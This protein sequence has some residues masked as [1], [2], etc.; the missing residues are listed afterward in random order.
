MKMNLSSDV[1]RTAHPARRRAGDEK[2]ARCGDRPSNVDL[3]T[4][5]AFVSAS[6]V[7]VS[8]YAQLLTTSGHRK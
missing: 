4:V 7:I 8:I 5:G 1:R 3:E 2:R 6:T